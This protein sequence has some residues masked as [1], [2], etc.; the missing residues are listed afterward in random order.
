MPVT[1]VFDFDAPPQ[2][3]QRGAALM[4]E[5]LGQ[6]DG[7]SAL[8]ARARRRTRIDRMVQAGARVD[9]A[10]E[11]IALQLPS[12]S[13]RRLDYDDGEW[14]CALSQR[15]ELPDW[16]DHCAEGRHADIALA[17]LEAAVEAHRLEGSATS[18]HA[19]RGCEAEPTLEETICCENF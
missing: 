3:A 2:I 1:T 19:R 17:L 14:H 12:W 10:L 15:R 4:A 5:L 16:L 6:A 11:L 8:S 7:I 9:A 18:S 13:L